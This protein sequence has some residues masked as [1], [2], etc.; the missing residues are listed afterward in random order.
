MSALKLITLV[1]LTCYPFVS[2]AHA[3]EERSRVLCYQNSPKWIDSID[4]PAPYKPTLMRSTYSV[5]ADEVLGGVAGHCE[6]SG[7]LM[8]CRPSA[9][10]SAIWMQVLANCKSKCECLIP[11]QVSKVAPGS[12]M[13]A[14]YPAYAM[15][16]AIIQ[17]AHKFFYPTGDDHGQ[18]YA[19]PRMLAGKIQVTAHP[20]AG[21]QGTNH[22]DPRQGQPS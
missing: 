1:L 5:C 19:D 16:L 10:N 8:T 21:L 14:H 6:C 9:T 7:S 3:T 11:G 13:A 4:W 12:V 18:A 22:V 15:S 20:A 2:P 17:E